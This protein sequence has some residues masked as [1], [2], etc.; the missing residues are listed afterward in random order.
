MGV[1]ISPTVMEVGFLIWSLL[2]Y[3]A[4][5]HCHPVAQ[6][7][8]ELDAISDVEKK[9]EKAIEAADPS[10]L[11]TALAGNPN[12]INIT[13]QHADKDQLGVALQES[14]LD[15]LKVVL[16]QS[17]PEL[18]MAAFEEV[19]EDITQLDDFEELENLVS[20]SNQGRDCQSKDEGYFGIC[21]TPDQCTNNEFSYS[22]TCSFQLSCCKH[23]V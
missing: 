17:K 12:L 5:I 8:D 10:V 20:A 4:A 18:L 6:F 1:I 3:L 19:Y 23:K 13:L 11:A 21:T 16:S 15:I 7:Q 22:V 2:P 9:I 14:N